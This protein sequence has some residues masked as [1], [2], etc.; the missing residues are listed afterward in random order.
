MNRE[1]I[2]EHSMQIIFQMDVAN[3]FDYSKLIPIEENAVTI[4]KKQTLTLLNAVRNHISD[5]DRVISA[6]LDKWSLDRIA[7]T[8]LAI[9]RTAVAEL[10]YIDDVPSAVS[11]NEAVNLAKKY[12]DSKSY[13]FVNSVLSK[14]EQYIKEQ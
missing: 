13:A 5:I 8:D 10:M 3:E 1:E 9:L 11:I 12:G 7:K 6:N 4:E 14:V 2:R